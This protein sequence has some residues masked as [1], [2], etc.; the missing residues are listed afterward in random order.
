MREKI[1]SCP[2]CSGYGIVQ[3]FVA[4]DN[5]QIEQCSTCKGRRGYRLA[6]R[7]SHRVKTGTPWR[8]TAK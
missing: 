8:E 5:I 4:E 6:P 1:N 3:V 2:D 7:G